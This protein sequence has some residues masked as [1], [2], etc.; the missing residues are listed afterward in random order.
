MSGLYLSQLKA[1]IVTP[2]LTTIGLASPAAINLLAGT[3][4]AESECVYLR[5]LGGG[6]ALGLWEMEPATHDDIWAN[7]L[8]ARIDFAVPIRRMT[9]TDIPRVRQLISNLRYACAMARIRYYR[10]PLPLPAANDAVGLCT[11]WKGIY[12]TALGAGAADATHIAAFQA[13]IDA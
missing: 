5:Q 4:S 6:P 10:S 9:T 11:Y 12:N 2:V 13:A 7:F 3:A 1:E 8:N